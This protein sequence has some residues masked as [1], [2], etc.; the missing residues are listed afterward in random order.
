[1]KTVAFHTI[2]C[3][4]NQYETNDL[5]RQFAEA[6]WEV[7]PFGEP[8]DVTVV[9]TCTV[10]G[11]SDHRCRAA[12]RKARRASPA[13]T[14]VAA[15]CY[16]QAQP[17]A[18]G[19]MA[20]VD[21]VLGN[22]GKAAVFEH[23]GEEGRPRGARIAIA[24]PAA[25]PAPGAPAPFVPIRAFSGH[26]RA[27]VKIQDGCDARCAYCIVPQ[28]RGGNRSLPETD[29]IAQ[30][31]ALIGAGYPEVVLT[32]VHLGTWGRDLRP[33]RTLAAVLAR[34]VA[35]PGLGR[36]RLSSIEPT[37]FTPELLE[38]LASSP[39]IC[40]H[41]HIPLQSGAAAVLRAMR[42][43]YGPGEF[44][45]LAE[46]LAATLPDPG[47]GA[48][49]IAGFP[50]ERA[51]DFEETAALIR[52]LPLTY[53]HVFPYS[54]RP[55]TPAA[56]MPDQ[57][58]PPERERRAALLRAIG[59]DKAEDFRRRHVGRTVRA[60]VEGRAGRAHGLTG[61]Y[62]KVEVRAGAADIG[63]FRD[64]RILRLDGGTLHGELLG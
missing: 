26:T 62:L 19:S 13:G 54:P 49:V 8:A 1:M 29:V 53:L 45:A 59:R 55:G 21:L 2:G 63:T 15:G 52:A 46:R 39:A 64:L 12:L 47:I 33:Q 17:D 58:P 61:N 35:L 10:T 50:G 27:F 4:L 34:I 16:A 7:V 56:A 5:E 42:R 11:R 23:L 30:V 36:L 57:V 40:P 41:L 28:A 44:A 9:N 48:D 51:E 31:E 43:P 24:G 38:L 18:V 14:V 37:E 22:R 3:K 20:E 6:G 60:L 25:G 32:G